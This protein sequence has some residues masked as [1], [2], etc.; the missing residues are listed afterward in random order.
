M[1]GG[2]SGL[3]PRPHNRLFDFEATARGTEWIDTIAA[4]A[5][6]VLARRPVEQLVIGHAD[7]AVKHF[8]FRGRHVRVIYDWDSLVLDEEAIPVGQAAR[9]FTM[10]WDLPVDLT[11]TPNE[12]RAFVADY[13]Q[14]RGTPFSAPERVRLGASA[15][16]ALAY[17]ARCEACADPKATEFPPGSARLALAH[18]AHEFLH[19]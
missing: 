19:L 13:E 5:R 3:W 17:T 16:Y 15:T 9:G 1:E 7:W 10:T 12:A 8:R 6:D 14:E 18:H 11:P 4:R 2:E